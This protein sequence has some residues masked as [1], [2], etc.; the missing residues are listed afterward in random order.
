[1]PDPSQLPYKFIDAHS[2]VFPDRI[3]DAIWAY[4]E[5]NY[6]H[7]NYRLYGN[8]IASFFQE[9]GCEGFT[10]L[11]YAHKPDISAFMNEYTAEFAKQHQKA[12]PFGTVHP[13]DNNLESI[14]EKALT[15]SNLKGF[16]LQLLVTD[17]FIDHERLM[18][19]Y[20]LLRREDKI[21]VVHAGTGPLANEY[22]GV[23]YFRRFLEKFG[24]LRI[25][26]AHL[27]CY[28]YAEFFEILSRTPNMIMDSAM[29]L[30]DHMLFPARFNID[31]K[32][33]LNFENQL[34]FGTDFPNIPYDF[35]HSYDFLLK[36]GFDHKFYEK[37]FY[38]NAK[39]FYKI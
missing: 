26:V 4:F 34:V 8:A 15:T 38:L 30:V 19:V 10:T 36:Q 16:K 1:M 25:Q 9:Q 18:P 28:E 21:L 17:F 20:N 22:V 31:Y 14:A 3:F 12:I 37:F 6:W 32:I 23:K 5:K 35:S 11:N 27:G 7:I 39:K 2:H 29:V 13:L 33:L 24:D